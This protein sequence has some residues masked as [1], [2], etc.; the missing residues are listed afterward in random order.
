MKI[1]R[2]VSAGW[3]LFNAMGE[4]E[5]RFDRRQLL[6]NLLQWRNVKAH[7]LP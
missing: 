2:G 1:V 4:T 6:A 5:T 3:S 7:S